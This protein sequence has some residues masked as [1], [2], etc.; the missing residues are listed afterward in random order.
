M[1]VVP[2]LRNVDEASEYYLLNF[3]MHRNDL[4]NFFI[5]G[6]PIVIGRFFIKKS[7]LNI[8]ILLL[9]IIATGFLF[10]RTAYLL[11]ILSFALYLIFSKR[12]KFLPIFVAVLFGLSLIISTVIVERATK[13]LQS[14]DSDEISAGRISSIWLPLIDECFEN[15]TKLLFGKGRYA[16]LSSNAAARGTILETIDHPHNM[17]LELVLDV[18]F[19]GLIVVSG[20][21]AVLLR[22]CYHAMR[23]SSKLITT[24]YYH[25]ITVSIISY[26]FAGM[27]GRSLFPV[28]S[29][30]YLWVIAGLAIALNRISDNAEQEHQ[31]GN[32]I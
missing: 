5:I 7:V 29:N 24:E 17:Y 6:F 8:S 26:F 22:K 16:I 27:T 21:F 32:Q 4:A 14:R 15:P 30:S 18:G 10:S 23:T 3:G 20:F 25:V 1:F 28:L 2:D 31:N 9:T 13:G 12:A 11:L 19:F